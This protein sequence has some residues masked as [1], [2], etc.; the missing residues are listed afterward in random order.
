MSAPAN[1]SPPTPTPS[2]DRPYAGLRVLDLSQGIAG[3]YC[4]MLLAQYGADVLK[5][6][7]AAGDWGRN[8]GRR[9]GPHTAMDLTANRGKRSLVL[10]LKNA[11]GRDLL[12]RLAA[13]CDVLIE[14]FRPGVCDKLGVGYEAVCKSNPRVLYVS[15]SAFGLRGPAR[16][17]P[18]T[19]T[20]AQ[21]FSGM[22][23]LNRDVDGAPRPTGF[24]T[25]DYATALYAFQ[26]LAAALAARPHETGGRH[27]DISLMQASGAL[28]AMKIVEEHIE[29]G[30]APKLNAPAGSYKTSDGW[31]AVTLSKE[32][33]FAA[34]C[35]TIGLPQLAADPRFAD[36]PARARHLAE[37]LPPIRDALRQ[38]T[39]HEW[40]TAFRAADVIAA[41][42]HDIAGWR[43]D[44]QVQAMGLVEE[45]KLADGATVPW[46]N[47][48]GMLPRAPQD[49]RRHWPKVGEHSAQ[50]LSEVLGLDDNEIQALRDGGV[51]PTR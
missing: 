26:A 11:T 20:V 7:P 46:I 36:F 2:Y 38:K 3:P 13:R 42:V 6:E 40:L 17:L 31:I 32:S 27:L 18:G 43:A 50:I 44:P 24:L 14:N 9:V 35:N 12:A 16:D 1:P 15:V 37:L 25:A 21:A 45:A 10:D 48:P 34:I 39:T 28:L 23:M 19:D 29:G 5:V 51:L 4:A 22:M 33:H 47:I 30:P 41:E 8:L 49:A